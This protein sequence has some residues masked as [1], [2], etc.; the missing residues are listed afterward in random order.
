MPQNKD[1][2]NPP[3]EIGSGVAIERRHRHLRAMAKRSPLDDP[4]VSSHAWARYK[5]L[6]LGMFGITTVVVIVASGAAAPSTGVS[7]RR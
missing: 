5:R 3:P 6:M 4:R 7:V 2:A 1:L